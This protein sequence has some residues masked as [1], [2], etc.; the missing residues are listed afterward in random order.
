MVNYM[1]NSAYFSV[2]SRRYFLEAL[3]TAPAQLRQKKQRF[4]HKISPLS[5]PEKCVEVVTFDT[6]RLRNFVS[7]RELFLTCSLGVRRSGFLPV[8]EGREGVCA[9]TESQTSNNTKIASGSVGR[10]GF[11]ALKEAGKWKL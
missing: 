2:N 4:G 10:R 7:D 1:V 8:P 6:K 9:E 11:D 5:L 3:L